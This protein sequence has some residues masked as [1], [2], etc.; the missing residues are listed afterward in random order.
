M[1]RLYQYQVKR[2][3]DET[4]ELIIAD[5]IEGKGVYLP[6]IGKF[7]MAHVRRKPAFNPIEMVPIEMP[8]RYLPK[9]KW[10]ERVYEHI[11]EGYNNRQSGDK[12]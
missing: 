5:L 4:C 8:D 12:R 6:K 11:K 9:F 3:L 2:I 1:T 10:G 7:W